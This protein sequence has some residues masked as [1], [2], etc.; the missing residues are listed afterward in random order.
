MGGHLPQASAVSPLPPTS[1]VQP[2]AAVTHGTALTSAL[3]ST[4]PLAVVP[5]LSKTL[6]VKLFTSLSALPTLKE[7]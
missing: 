7:G 3:G 4:F 2:L 5:A 6:C 1:P